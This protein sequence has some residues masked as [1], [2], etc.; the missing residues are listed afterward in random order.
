[1]LRSKLNF[2]DLAGSERWNKEVSAHRLAGRAGGHGCE[3][4]TEF[5]AY[6]SACMRIGVAPCL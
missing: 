2:V 1:M 6:W 4:C 3:G 5:L